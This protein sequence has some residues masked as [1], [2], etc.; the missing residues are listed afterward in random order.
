[1]E[2]NDAWFQ[3]LH[4]CTLK[5]HVFFW[6]FLYSGLAIE[7]ASEVFPGVFWDKKGHE[8]GIHLRQQ[9]LK[10]VYIVFFSWNKH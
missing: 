7:E 9:S 10:K 8:F 4:F 2:R 3:K 5:R 6:G 1:M